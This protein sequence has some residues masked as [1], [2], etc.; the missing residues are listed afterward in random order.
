MH[1]LQLFVIGVPGTGKTFAFKV[2]SSEIILTLGDKW[3]ENVRL[4]TPTG[5]VSFHMGFVILMFYLYFQV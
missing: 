5:S 4:A 1:P 3:Q 2:S